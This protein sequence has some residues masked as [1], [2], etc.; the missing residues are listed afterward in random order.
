VK[1][2]PK[3]GTAILYD[4]KRGIFTGHWSMEPKKKNSTQLVRKYQVT[5][6]AG[7]FVR[8]TEDEVLA[9]VEIETTLKIPPPSPPRQWFA[10]GQRVLTNEGE[11]I[12][13]KVYWGAVLALIKSLREIMW[14]VCCLPERR[15]LELVFGML[16]RS[17]GVEYEVVLLGTGEIVGL[18]GSRLES[19]E[20]RELAA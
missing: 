12:V 14:I 1:K 8:L 13:T 15:S 20:V 11:G 4:G 10:V 7:Q 2:L 18:A 3:P 16:L 17:Y 19:V 5:Y 6:G 9:K